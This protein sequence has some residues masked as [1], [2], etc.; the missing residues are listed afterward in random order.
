[1]GYAIKK[2]ISLDSSRIFV[3]AVI[4]NYPWERAQSALYRAKDGSVILWWQGFVNV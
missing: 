2:F 1:M 4:L 3:I